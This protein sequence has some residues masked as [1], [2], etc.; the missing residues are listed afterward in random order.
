MKR[1]ALGLSL[2]LASCGGSKAAPPTPAP[3]DDPE[4]VVATASVEDWLEEQRAASPEGALVG[5]GVSENAEDAKAIA[6]EA[7]EV[8][9]WGEEPWAALPEGSEIDSG[10]PSVFD[11]VSVN[12]T[13]IEGQFAA[14]A[15]TAVEPISESAFRWY[16]A[17]LAALPSEDGEGFAAALRRRTAV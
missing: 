4:P 1:L 13:E 3:G 7:L 11:E 16:D 2:A 6:L 12:E 8:A 17:A 15:T 5:H 14:F 10:R 9:F